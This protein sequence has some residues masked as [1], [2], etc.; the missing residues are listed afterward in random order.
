MPDLRV[1]AI[2][3]DASVGAVEANLA[4]AQAL[5]EQAAGQGAQLV[6]LP[7][8]FNTGYEYTDRNFALAEPPDGRTGTWLRAMARRLGIHLAA[9]FPIRS[10]A[11]AA[12]TAVLAAPDGRQWAYQKMHV[13]IWENA[14]F[15]RG[16]QPVVADTDLGRIGLLICWDQVFSDLARAYQGRVDLLC[17]PS[18]PPIFAGQFEDERGQVLARVGP[19]RI[20]GATLDA[21][22][23]FGQATA[24]HARS[25][26]VPAVYAPRC[27]SF[28]SPI[29]YG[30]L[31][32]AGWGPRVAA[33]VLRGAG[34]HFRM[35]C[36]LMGRARILDRTGAPLAQ[37]G[38]DE[39]AILVA[40][41]QPGAPDPATLP[42]LPAPSRRSI[43]PDFPAI[44][45][46]LDGL[47]IALGRRYRRRHDTI[48][49]M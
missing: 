25:A 12:I 21:V 9:A 5:V 48:Y 45:L 10:P 29:P 23:W 41:V 44:Q 18:S 2:Q 32:L 40:T 34:T 43:V 42:P 16:T 19:A 15:V 38:Q 4:H 3:M 33:R 31:F 7:E 11:G 26:G 35:R 6:V 46:W 14:Y 24:L 13:A 37:A 47:A 8:L 49:K 17:I 36:P 1:A 39:E 20:L 22:S 28:C 27:G 30:L